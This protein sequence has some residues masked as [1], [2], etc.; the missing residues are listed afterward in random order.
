MKVDCTFGDTELTVVATE[1]DTNINF[2]N[3]VLD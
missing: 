1:K 3:I 2:E